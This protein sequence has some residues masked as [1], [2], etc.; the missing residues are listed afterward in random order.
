MPR[1]VYDKTLMSKLM[2]QL[3]KPD[4]KA[5]F[6][7]AKATKRTLGGKGETVFWD[8]PEQLVV[9]MHTVLKRELSWARKPDSC[10]AQNLA[11]QVRIL[12]AYA[13]EN[14]PDA[15]LT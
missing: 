1:I 9:G 12:E 6:E 10:S 2:T 15:V 14:Y 3:N 4:N 11:N 13:K 5:L 8:P 7:L